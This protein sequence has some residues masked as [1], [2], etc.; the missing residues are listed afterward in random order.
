MHAVLKEHREGRW[1]KKMFNGWGREKKRTA[2]RIFRKFGCGGR[3]EI[4]VNPKFRMSD[5]I[6]TVGLPGQGGGLKECIYIKV[7][8]CEENLILSKTGRIVLVKNK[9]EPTNTN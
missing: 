9:G 5:R 8:G 6:I 1:W 2:A 4:A 7:G 3:G